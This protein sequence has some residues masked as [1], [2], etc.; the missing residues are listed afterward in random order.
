MLPLNAYNDNTIQC[1]TNTN[2]MLI[3]YNASS[4]SKLYSRQVPST[5]VAPHLHSNGFGGGG[6]FV[7]NHRKRR[8]PV[9]SLASLISVIIGGA[10]CGSPGRTQ[11]EDNRLAGAN[12]GRP[13]KD[14]L[15]HKH[16]HHFFFRQQIVR[17]CQER[18]EGP[19]SLDIPQSTW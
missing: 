5:N 8:P 17:N 10:G 9:G 6:D 15:S 16:P 1:Y 2:T 7:W 3:V 19:S 13:V 11:D 18:F 4:H 14:I 12:G